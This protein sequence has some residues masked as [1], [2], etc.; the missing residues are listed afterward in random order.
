MVDNNTTYCSIRDVRR[1]LPEATNTNISD[2]TIRYFIEDAQDMIDSRF[3]GTYDVPFTTV[4][5]EVNKLC[6]RIATYL[7]MQNFP[8]RTV[9]EDLAN[10]RE[11]IMDLLNGY[12]KGKYKLPPEYLSSNKT[13]TSATFTT[14]NNSPYD[15]LYG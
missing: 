11:D 1:R 3:R 14:Q 12:V 10:L 4:P 9:E 8:D 7:T 15:D 6:S 2:S 13:Y 5:S